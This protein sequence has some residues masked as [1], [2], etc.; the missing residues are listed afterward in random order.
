MPRLA[1]KRLCKNCLIAN[2]PRFVSRTTHA[3]ACAIGRH[4]I[5]FIAWILASNRIT[6]RSVSSAIECRSTRFAKL[7]ADVVAAEAVGTIPTNALTAR[8]ASHSIEA[9]ARAQA[10]AVLTIKTGRRGIHI[11]AREWNHG[12][13]TYGTR[14]IACFAG[15]GARGRTTNTVHTKSAHA[16][17]RR[18]ARGAIGLSPTATSTH[19]CAITISSWTLVLRI[20]AIEN[21][22]TCAI[23]VSGER[24]RA[25]ITG[26]VTKSAATKSIHAKPT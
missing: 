13:R 2:G 7:I 5:A 9:N 12:T 22:S 1:T 6:A 11:R 26:L 17:R 25:P 15:L 20:G 19:P 21:R 10:I 16:L 14:P 24:R 3:H 8:H 18:H 23:V 4:A